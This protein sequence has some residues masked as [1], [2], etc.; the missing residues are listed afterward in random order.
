MT[1]LASRLGTWPGAGGDKK[2][3]MGITQETVAED[4]E[5]AWGVAE[6][7]GNLL[8]GAA[9]EEIGAEGFVLALHGELRG[10]EEVLVSLCRYLIRSAGLHIS[11]VLP[12][13]STVN[14][15]R[16]KPGS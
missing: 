11:I 1:P 6:G 15:F 12:K 7:A 2:A 10:E 5:G 9:L 16:G 14:M 8:G 4:A 3:R 13:H